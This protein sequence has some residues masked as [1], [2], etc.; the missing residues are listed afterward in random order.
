M[1]APDMVEDHWSIRAADNRKQAVPFT[2]KNSLNVE[3]SMSIYVLLAVSY[4]QGLA[5]SLYSLAAVC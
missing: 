2:V 1:G 5:I 4:L 3:H